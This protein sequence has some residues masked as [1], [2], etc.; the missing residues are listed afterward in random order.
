M[1]GRGLTAC[2]LLCALG[3]H[4]AHGALLVAPFLGVGAGVIS[5]CYPGIRAARITPMAALRS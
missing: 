1:S 3:E 4:S 2:R 5:G